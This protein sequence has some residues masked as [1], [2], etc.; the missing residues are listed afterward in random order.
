ML[1]NSAG[2]SK[3]TIHLPSESSYDEIHFYTSI[4]QNMSTTVQK[5]KTNSTGAEEYSKIASQLAGTYGEDSA[6]VR[7]DVQT[8]RGQVAASNMSPLQ[9]PVASPVP[10]TAAA[11]IGEPLSYIFRRPTSTTTFPVP[12][13]PPIGEHR[14]TPKSDKVGSIMV[15]DMQSSVLDTANHYSAHSNDSNHPLHL[16]PYHSF[17]TIP[18]SHVNL[19]RRWVPQESHNPATPSWL[20]SD[21]SVGKQGG[22]L[23]NRGYGGYFLGAHDDNPTYSSDG[24]SCSSGVHSR[25][26][27]RSQSDSVICGRFDLGS[28]DGLYTSLSGQKQCVQDTKIV[29]SSDSDGIP[30]GSPIPHVGKLSTSGVKDLLSPP[31]LQEQTGLGSSVETRM[32][33]QRNEWFPPI[34]SKCELQEGSIREIR[35]NSEILMRGGFDLSDE[36]SLLRPTVSG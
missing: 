13:V 19:L 21:V 15:S 10:S 27:A 17:L 2:L 11:R 9:L 23:T 29:Q 24:F 35:S 8:D 33:E 3:I 18:L 4:P 25:T 16:L 34:Q 22:D 7:N 20:S 36:Q 5:Q 28:D 30:E 6:T 12:D 32:V 26:R 1:Q 31:T 14:G